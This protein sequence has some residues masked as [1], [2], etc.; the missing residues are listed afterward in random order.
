MPT[1]RPDNA[2]DLA[3]TLLRVTSA[4]GQPLDPTVAAVLRRV[5]ERGEQKK[6]G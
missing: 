6:T 4:Q 2:A 5:L 3:R 1:P